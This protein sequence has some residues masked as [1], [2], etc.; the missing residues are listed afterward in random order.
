MMIPSTRDVVSLVA[1]F[2]PSTMTGESES[3]ESSHEHQ[4]FGIPFITSML[5]FILIAVPL[6]QGLF[7]SWLAR[8][9]FP[10]NELKL[11]RI[12]H[13]ATRVPAVLVNV[14]PEKRLRGLSLWEG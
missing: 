8:S 7:L 13:F 4:D 14:E 6:D 5:A 1:V 12:G 11:V 2:S 10:I 9:R 3:K